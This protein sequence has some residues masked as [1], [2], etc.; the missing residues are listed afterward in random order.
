MDNGLV[1]R[2][3][4][5][6]LE[7][8]ALKT[9]SKYT[10]VRSVRTAYS[11]RVS[12]GIYRIDY[13]TNGESIISLFYTDK[14]SDI[15]GGVYPRTPQGSSQIVEVMTTYVKPNPGG[16]PTSETYSLAFVV[17]SNVPVTSITR[18]S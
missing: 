17:V 11:G 15:T 2:L 4:R 10:S 7:L 8:L 13:Q 9:A 5:I 1:D 12:T 3:K 6:E 18:I 16:S 14:N